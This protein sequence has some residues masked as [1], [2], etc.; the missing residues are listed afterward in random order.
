MDEKK[1]DVGMVGYHYCSEVVLTEPFPV[2]VR[3]GEAL[4]IASSLL[5]VRSYWFVLLY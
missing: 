2:Y 3:V 5:C 1:P 4:K